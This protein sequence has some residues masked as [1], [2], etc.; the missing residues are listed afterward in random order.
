L[1]FYSNQH[2]ILSV[3]VF[4][5]YGIIFCVNT[6]AQSATFKFENITHEQGLP[7]RVVNAITQDSKGFMWFGS[8][9]GLTRYDGYT[10]KV[11]RHQAG[12][13]HSLSGNAVYALCADINGDIWVGT[14]NGLCRYNAVNNRFDVFLHDSTNNKSI[15][16]NQIFA[17]AK[18]TQGQLWIGTYGGGLDK[19][20]INN[21]KYTFKHFQNV[22]SDNKSIAAN[23]VFSIV[24]DK[25]GFGWVGTTNG[26]NILDPQ[27]EKFY[28]FTHKNGDANSIS[29]NNVNRISVGKDGSVLIAG[30]A[31]LDKVNFNPATKTISVTH[32]LPLVSNYTK[33]EWIVNDAITDNKGIYWLAL[34]DL[35]LV[36]C[37]PVNNKNV[38]QTTTYLHAPQNT[39]SLASS[40]VYCLYQDRAGLI[41][42]GTSKGV[43]KYI[44]AKEIF[45]DSYVLSHFITP[46]RFIL[47][48]AT[49]NQNRLWLASDTDTL[50]VL[51]RDQN[52]NWSQQII[53]PV[54]TSNGFDQINTMFTSKSGDLYIGTMSGGFFVVPASAKILNKSGWISINKAK[55][56]SLPSNNVYAFGEDNKGNILIGTYKGLCRYNRQNNILEPLYINNSAAILPE[57]TIRSI[58]T[59]PDGNYW[60]GTDNGIQVIHHKQIV[61]S[62]SASPAATGLSNNNITSMLK[63]SRGNIWVGT[64]DGL[65]C[66]FQGRDSVVRFSTRNG[67]SDDGI[68]SVIEDLAGNIWIATNHGLTKYN[69]A[70][71]HFYIY[72]AKD[73]LVTDQ[74]VTNSVASDSKGILYFGTNNGLVYFNPAAIQPNTYIPPVVITQVKVFNK[75][76]EELEDTSIVLNYQQKQQLILPYNQNFFTFEF[77]ALNY[78]NTSNNLYA[79]M[80][81]G[82]DHGWNYSGNL[83]IASYTDIKSGHYTFKVKGANNDG[84]WNNQLSIINVIITPPWWQTWWF[85]A[86]CCIIFCLLVYITY[87]VRLKQVLQL[88]KL[89]SSI[90]KDLHD[91]VGS[92]LS[93]IAMLSN[94]AQDGKTTAHLKPDEI[95]S[96]IG[97]TSKRMI[98][99]M[100]DIVWSVNPDNDRFNN[101]LIR[102]RE[103]AVEMLEIKDI[104]FTFRVAADI[105]ELRL[106]MQMRKDYFLIYKEAINNLT[107]YANCTQA[108]ISIEHI[109]RNIITTVADNGNGFNP[110]IITSGNGLRNMQAR[111]TSL[112]GRLEYKTGIG[113]GTQVILTISMV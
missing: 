61:K 69:L 89:R 90:A 35:G 44:P 59:N 5:L 10:C 32:V 60:C 36:M 70:Q 73:G 79:Y 40:N 86:I 19:L 42:I 26:L 65:N 25:Q 82:V 49:D 83:R 85:Y 37:S 45:N 7:D 14:N 17:L 74:F 46:N 99:L 56:A 112:K 28:R 75:N 77:A 52:N 48:I 100:D 58:I 88:Y 34:N 23:E 93:S 53:S 98:D 15:S 43:S 71:K 29:N 27:I 106:P 57:F 6:S 4:Y 63:D 51:N 3:L 103:Y 11:F 91:D 2:H 62:Y 50:N 55:Y 33:E 64:K 24:F 18:D 39:G 47:A 109:G 84:L 87:R 72:T 30:Y 104:A 66:F 22:A 8:E 41:W 1:I 38:F 111:A 80:L 68:R 97:D 92:A 113:K 31:L 21:G 67:L 13:D 54:L 102:M 76:I 81:E 94:I 20:E 12:N 101:M 107:K 78:T 105:G 110:A 96:R 108:T 16:S 9:E 95:F